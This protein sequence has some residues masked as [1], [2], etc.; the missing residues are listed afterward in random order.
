MVRKGETIEAEPMT[1]D[2]KARK[3]A[4]LEEVRNYEFL[5]LEQP[6]LMQK[7]PYGTT[8]NHKVYTLFHGGT[9]PLPRK[10][11]M[12]LESCRVPLWKWTP[13]GQGKMVKTSAG[14]QP[15]F[16]CREVYS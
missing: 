14:S 11:A 4:W 1:S 13:D 3:A 2:E 8:K 16:Q 15:R 9:Y 6:G 5:N 12:H 7:F 10:V